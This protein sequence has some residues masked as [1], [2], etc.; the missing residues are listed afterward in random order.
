MAM[1]A[2]KVGTLAEEM[3]VTIPPL[4]RRG[5]REKPKPQ[6]LSSPANIAKWFA[7]LVC[8]SFA[9][10]LVS[11]LILIEAKFCNWQKRQIQAKEMQVQQLKASIALRFSK[12][13]VK[14]AHSQ[15]LQGNPTLLRIEMPKSK[16]TLLGRR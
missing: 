11:M 15:S 10:C 9:W 7:P 5:R 4:P 6:S 8:L 1:S 14:P 2:R 16:T 13:S 12:L 3:A